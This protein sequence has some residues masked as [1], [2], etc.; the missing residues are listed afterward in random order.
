MYG[1]SGIV[2]AT[3]FF[4]D[5]SGLSGVGGIGANDNI[6]TT[7]I[8][9][10]SAFA[11]FKYL[12]APFGSTVNFTVTVDS[13]NA[14]HRYNGQG[15]GQAYIINGVQS[16]FLTLT[17]GRTYRFNLSASDQSSHPFRFYLE[18][19]KTTE[20]STNVTT[21]ATYT[22]ITVSDTTPNVL[23]YQCSSH[24]LMGNAVV[25]NSNVVDTPYP[26]TLRDGLNVTGISSVGSAITMYGAS[27]IISATKFIGDGSSLTGIT[28]DTLGDLASLKVTGLSTFNDNVDI[29]ADVDI[30][31]NLSIGGTLTY[32]D[33]TNVDS[34]GLITARDGIA[35][36]GSGLTVTGLSTFYSEVNV[37]S[38]ITMG[39][40][41]GIIS[42]TKF[43]GDGSSLTGISADTLGDLASL[44]VTGIATFDNNIHANGNI[45]GDGAT[46]ISG[47][48]TIGASTYYGDGSQLTGIGGGTQPGQVA[49]ASTA[50]ISTLTSSWIVA[51]D[52]SDHFQLT[53]PGNLSSANNPTIYLQRGQIYEFVINSNSSHPF[54]IRKTDNSA[55]TDGV[56]YTGTGG[57]NSI[58]DGT[59]RF[60]VPFDAP[61]ELKYVCTNHS[62]DMVG[63]IYVTDAAGQGGP[64]DVAE[65]QNLKVSVA[66]T[67]GTVEVSSGVITASNP[68]SGI[69]TYY[70]DGQ[71]LTG[72]TAEGT[73]AIGGLTVKDEG[74]TVGTAGSVST[75]NF[76]G[77][78]I[79]VVANTG[80]A[81]VATITVSANDAQENVYLGTNAGNASDA[82]TCFNVALGY[83]AGASLDAG[84][85]NV[86]LG[87]CAGTNATS[88][89]NNVFLG[90][91]V[92]T[93]VV[94]GSHNVAIGNDLLGN[95]TSGTKSIAIGYGLLNNNSTTASC[96]IAIGADSLLGVDSTAERNISLGFGN[97]NNFLVKG[98]DNIAIGYH[99]GPGYCNT[100]NTNI[101][102]GHS[103]GSCAGSYNISMGKVVGDSYSSG[104][105]NIGLGW[106][107]LPV[108]NTGTYNIAFGACAGCSL[109]SGS[110]N[111]LFGCNAGSGILN[112]GRNIIF[113]DNA[114][115]ASICG[116]HNI[117]M[118]CQAMSA[119]TGGAGDCNVVLGMK[120]GLSLSGAGA[121]RNIFLGVCAANTTTTGSNNI[122][123][124]FDV[125]LP[126]ATG[127]CQLAIG[128]GTNRWIT[129]DSSFNTTLAGIATVYSA[130]GIVSATK[131]CATSFV[132]SGASLTG[133]KFNVNDSDNNLFAGVG[134]GGT[135]A[136]GSVSCFNLA[137]GCA[138]MGGMT[139]STFGS[140]HNVAIGCCSLFNIN[141]G[142]CNFVGGYQ[143]GRA[144]TSGCNNI[145]VGRSAGRC[146]S[147]TSGNIYLGECAGH[148]S[149]GG[150]NG[151]DDNI[152]IGFKA[153]NYRCGGAS[154]SCNI[155][156]GYCSG[157]VGKGSF[158]ISLGKH[159]LFGSVF[160]GCN[161]IGIGNSTGYC[162]N[163]GS[164]NIILGRT[165]GY[166]IKDGCDNITIG[167]SAGYNIEDGNDNIFVGARAGVWT[168]NG[169]RNVMLGGN[170]GGS[171]SRSCCSTGN[172]NQF[173]GYCAGAL[174]CSGGINL[175]LGPF[176]GAT[177]STGSYNIAIGPEVCLPSATGSCQL[178][179]GKGS[180]RWI[181]GDSSFNV[182][183]AGS[184]IKAINSGG[185][186]C[187]TKFVGDG[188][189][190]S[191]IITATGINTTTTS[192]FNDLTV[193]GVSTFLGSVGIG[194]TNSNHYNLRVD[195]GAAKS[196][197]QVVGSTGTLLDVVNDATSDIFSANDVSGI[198]AFKINKDRLITM[199]LVGAGDSVGIGTTLPRSS[200]KL[201]VE[202]IVKA[203]S[204]LGDGSTLDN[205][206]F[207]QD[208]QG[209][210]IAGTGAGAAKDADTCFNI[211]L[212][213]NSGAALCGGYGH[214]ILM[215][216]HAGK[217]IT[218]GGYN[219][220]FGKRV[221]CS[222]DTG[223][224][225]ILMGTSVAT[226]LTTGCKNIAFIG[227]DSLGAT[228]CCNIIMG[229]EA[230]YNLTGNSNIVMGAQAG[231]DLTGDLNILLGRRAGEEMTSGSDNIALG[232]C[233]MGNGVVT[234]NYNVAMGYLSLKNLT[235]GNG[236]VSIGHFAGENVFNKCCNVFLGWYAGR[237]SCNHQN[238]MIGRNAGR[239]SSTPS[240]N[241]GTQN[242]FMG[243]DAASGY[244]E[245][246]SNIFLGTY[247]GGSLTTGCCNIVFGRQAGR[248]IST[249]SRNIVMGFC[250]CVADG[251]A[252]CQLA[253]GHDTNRW[254]TGDSS[255]NTT[256]AGIATVY[257]A[258][259]IVSATKFCGDGSALT[260]ISAGFSPDSQENLYAGTGA[261]AISDADTCFNI[262]IGYSALTNLQ[263]TGDPTGSGNVAIGAYAGLC[264]TNGCRNIL[265]GCYA[266]KCITSGKTTTA[267]GHQAARD[268]RSGEYNAFFGSY[269]GMSGCSGSKNT[270]VGSSALKNIGS[271]GNSDHNTGLGHAAGRCLQNACNN[272]FIGAY[273]GGGEVLCGDLN[274]AVGYKAGCKITT[275]QYNIFLGQYGGSSA[276]LTGQSNIA[277]G[278]KTG[279]CISSG[280]NNIA[281][282]CKVMEGA[283]I[284]GMNNIAMGVEAGNKL[285]SGCYNLFFGY[286]AGSNQN[287]TGSN[288]IFLGKNTG[289]CASSAS[290]NVVIGTDSAEKLTTGDGNIIL[291]CTAADQGTLTGSIN[292]IIGAQAG[293]NIAGGQTNV[294]L[295][296]KAGCDI[297]S[298]E[299]N[300]FIGA[301]AGLCHQTGARNIAIG[302]NTKL[303]MENTGC[304][305]AI[306][307]GDNYW[308]VGNSDYN[309]GIGTTNP[310]AA[311][312]SGN[313]KKLSVGILSAY[314]LYGDGSGLTGL[315]GFSPDA[316][317]NLV[318]GTDAGANFD[319]TSACNNIFLGAC[320]GKD[321]E[322]GCYNI[323]LGQNAGRRFCASTAKNNIAIGRNAM[324][325]CNGFTYGKGTGC[326]NIAM[327]CQAMQQITSG[328]YNIAFGYCAGKLVGAGNCNIFFGHLAGANMCCHNNI[329]IGECAMYGSATGSGS[330]GCYNIAIGSHSGRCTTT[331]K[332][333][334]T[335]GREAGRRLTTGGCNIILGTSAGREIETGIENIILG[336]SAGKAAMTGC[337]NF[338]VGDSSGENIVSGMKNI[339]LGDKTGCCVIS[340]KYNV[341]FG[342]YTGRLSSGSNN[343]L[344]GRC[345]NSPIASGDS[346]LAIGY[347]SNNWIVGNSEFN[348]GIGTTN[349]NASVGVGNTAKLSVGIL[350]AY[351]L[352]G[353]GSALTG[354]SAGGF[355]ADDDLNLMASNTCSGC[356]LDGSSGCF[357]VFI[358][359]CAGK[360]VTSGANN[361]FIGDNAG[362]TAT[363]SDDNINIGQCAG[364]SNNN[365][366]NVHIGEHAAKCSTT[367]KRNTVVG[368]YAGNSISTG[369]Y[370]VVF[371]TYAGTYSGCNGTLTGSCNIIIGTILGGGKLTSGCDNI[372]MGCHAGLKL[373][374]GN[375]NIFIGAGAGCCRTSA[376]RDV[377]IGFR[378][379]FA[380][381]SGG[382]QI[383]IGSQS[384]EYNCCGCNVTIGSRAGYQDYCGMR[385]VYVGHNAGYYGS[386]TAGSNT[387][388]GHHA[389]YG[390]SSTSCG[391]E[392]TAIGCR[393][394]Y[395]MKD[396]CYNVTLGNCAGRANTDGNCNTFL[397]FAAG[398]TNTTGDGN[399]AI[400]Y[401]VELPSATDDN[402]MAIGSGSSRW[403]TGDSSYN[404]DIPNT[405]SKGGG[406]FK[407]DHPHPTKTETHHLVHS[408]IEGPQIDLIYR[409]KVDLVAGS[410]TVNLDTKAGMT[411]G[412]FVLLNRDVQSFTTNETGWG[413]VK[414]SVSGNILTITAQDNTSTDTISWMVIGERQ[415][416]KIKSLSMTDD[417]GNLIVE[418]LKS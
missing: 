103:V 379:N 19:D 272:T 252:D 354:I 155:A 377:L 384:G 340:G 70:G 185:I 292:V 400:G 230:G 67:L 361:T 309:V 302:Y 290:S 136:G 15:S 24:V 72:I 166:D 307:N 3:K 17:P 391:S 339:M 393:A 395:S 139:N 239:G 144:L 383:S 164:D 389:L 147:T 392:N 21:T 138:A 145:F 218:T 125:E 207:T 123:L 323:F 319:G 120:A 234:G 266:G 39:S 208:D 217:S 293:R 37:G 284:T 116:Q 322:S 410:A 382:A 146:Q 16:P 227:G 10:A 294:L 299:Q 226:S 129:G 287:V 303:P 360:A 193:T 281:L 180:D 46:I 118:G 329:A 316:D 192:T 376:T 262:G 328:C 399:V 212:G 359:A 11:G 246:S 336:Q 109:T 375:Q 197:F 81:G 181:T 131:F 140:S 179:I 8:I 141:D 186:F 255:F 310:N 403:I 308:I 202:G 80:A 345:V 409:G 283:T 79:S 205:V 244:T 277:I 93:G 84:D 349:P 240:D 386:N 124:G 203:T 256:L 387:A 27:G 235:T 257:S 295:G 111:I 357:N 243:T 30:S 416:D 165:A 206:G 13:K 297:T 313:T 396:G 130:T 169:C 106:C 66:S 34:I 273:A 219:L 278:H 156:L 381:E 210:L 282:G 190:L 232:T 335:I 83:K 41:S 221:G 6:N 296:Y 176:A 209:N 187:A 99:A 177:N 306:S 332:Y 175:F 101:A 178:A 69:V 55:Y 397:G 92:D 85:E 127:N 97:L 171:E 265:I 110:G 135:Y 112:G 35:V 388:I 271:G 390:D 44:K 114:G 334:V 98:V 50:G 149:T 369:C 330:C 90:S 211:M 348:V 53:G 267:I 73:G 325:A 305:L 162:L 263:G 364:Y 291:G 23:H 288:N 121:N 38:A 148:Q 22:E 298:A 191:G 47:I 366:A 233:A 40:S 398:N 1:S 25:T 238:I 115:T 133:T 405:L 143:A 320:A 151:G 88:G 411:E 117:I 137:L 75:L 317:E 26:A 412:T 215:G 385:S 51:P 394:S 61:T 198:N 331:A 404:V 358:G 312:T 4:G 154:S 260:G 406:S 14:T 356:S 241:S 199:A 68:S 58:Y 338:L 195:A 216:C 274:T 414:S 408:F 157:Y 91:V 60:D 49:F 247:V 415:D 253:I 168:C 258:T 31:G 36:L 102:I 342:S 304:Q 96:N 279:R 236:N 152:A 183:L 182:C 269:A 343:I 249:G 29:N 223:N 321:L 372:L 48:S 65:F 86:F 378:A 346:Q 224:A 28:A 213:C 300:V 275:G 77:D 285:T 367:G 95:L 413:A 370:N 237:C 333:N 270:A 337:R 229:N 220:L 264:M 32:E 350:S 245:A 326:H 5:G 418:P 71:Y 268:M 347:I 74:S 170:A 417:D 172:Y 62:G 12:Q 59:V 314:Q 204:F 374:S 289:C 402:Q 150:G 82:D 351:Q 89:S 373:A 401:D 105:H 45:I 280:S 201:D 7:G 301:V 64:T 87:C 315:A 9:T 142:G 153:A 259:G 108:A 2:S 311:V 200:S 371:G 128:D 56:T 365:D 189:S 344:I 173:I 94:T 250:V 161:N 132:G 380:N 214:S 407:I 276:E 76:V 242:I 324:C 126:D 18:A 327:G 184:N 119:G 163:D 368:S 261:G 362:Y 254:L 158:N 107:I 113:G 122:A 57:T 63:V 194:T 52:G 352:Y 228:A 248:N 78:I 104:N 42:A 196:A 231:C 167:R 20:Y 160:C 225:N 43:I 134:A 318:A 188:S 100:C 159:A 33:V 222:I 251:T 174:T 341:F 54:Q 286:Y 363:D 355:S 353:D